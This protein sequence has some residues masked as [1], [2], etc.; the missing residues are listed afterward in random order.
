[1]KD[2]NTKDKI[3]D[4]VHNQLSRMSDEGM[5]EIDELHAKLKK[6]QATYDEKISEIEE[7][8]RRRPKVLNIPPL[9][10]SNTSEAKTVKLL[11][12]K[13]K[14]VK[15]LK[16]KIANKSKYEDQQKHES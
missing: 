4:E 13:D 1:M 2:I 5:R 6:F 15:Y 9:E 14:F 12:E 8:L 10:N 16:A 7:E 3:I 11:N